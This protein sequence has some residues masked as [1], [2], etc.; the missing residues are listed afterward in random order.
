MPDIRASPC[1]IEDNGMKSVV[2]LVIELFAFT[3]YLAG[4]SLGQVTTAQYG[5]A[6]TGAVTTETALTPSNV[7]SSTF[8]KIATFQVDGDVY[9]QPLY[10]PRLDLPRLGTRAVLFVAPEHGREYAFDPAR[11]SSRRWRFE[12][13]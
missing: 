10:L 12:R 4:V 13:R 3:A 6:R 5:N 9:A 8:G 11:R 2:R 7:R 1:L